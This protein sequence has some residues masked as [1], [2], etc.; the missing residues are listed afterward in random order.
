ML[1][2]NHILISVPIV[3]KLEEIGEE[4]KFINEYENAITVFN[5]F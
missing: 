4:I 3:K 2:P 5:A 1:S